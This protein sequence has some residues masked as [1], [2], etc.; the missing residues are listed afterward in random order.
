MPASV[1]VVFPRTLSYP[2]T[3]PPSPF[4]LP[5]Q[6]TVKVRI[7]KGPQEDGSQDVVTLIDGKIHNAPKLFTP[8]SYFRT[9][10]VPQ[11]C[12]IGVRRVHL[13]PSWSLQRGGWG[14]VMD[15]LGAAG[16]QIR[17]LLP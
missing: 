4:P 17:H 16:Q 13:T 2:L 10:T 11:Y 7:S 15:H 14:D 3:L 12:S 8:V 9:A 6:A 5:H 1:G